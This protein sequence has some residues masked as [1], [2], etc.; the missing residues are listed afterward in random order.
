MNNLT[1]QEFVFEEN[2][3]GI[4]IVR[5]YGYDDTAVI[6]EEIDGKKVTALAPYAFSAHMDQAPVH[7]DIPTVCGEQL[8]RII[9]PETLLMIGRYAFYNCSNLEEMEF[10]SGLSN[11]GAGLFT[12]CHKIRRLTVHFH[13]EETSCLKE[14]LSELHEEM[15]VTIYDDGQGLFMF[16]EFY[17]EGV[18]NTPARILET[19]VHGSGLF[20]RNCFQQKRLNIR[21]YD[22]RFIQA[23]AMESK[24]FLIR[25]VLG[26]LMYPIELLEMPKKKYEAY[27]Q[28]EKEAFVKFLIDEGD[29]SKLEWLADTYGIEKEVLEKTLSDIAMRDCPQILSYL[30]DY[31]HRYYPIKRQTFDL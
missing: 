24:A 4:T 5:C 25:L 13:N 10:H 19:H 27:L 28:K 16:P 14:I 2:A 21:E 22:E 29:V 18:E 15:Q 9:L 11:L 30:M 6:P 8:K 7:T 17:E 3:Q 20:Y 31:K 12:G 23:K 26:R 1:A